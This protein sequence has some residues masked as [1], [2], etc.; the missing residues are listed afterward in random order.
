MDDCPGRVGR[1][2]ASLG[3]PDQ[4]AVK[5]WRAD[6]GTKDDIGMTAIRRNRKTV[7]RAKFPGTRSRLPVAEE[8]HGRIVI[9]Q[10]KIV[11]GC[12]EI[13][14]DRFVGRHRHVQRMG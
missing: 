6:V 8:G 7:I 9:V 14:R 13:R 5:S 4:Y 1:A 10:Y 11:G 2:V 3:I 12:G